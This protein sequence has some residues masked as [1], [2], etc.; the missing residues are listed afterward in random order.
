M[1]LVLGALAPALTPLPRR[2][3]MTATVG[4]VRPAGRGF[5]LMELLV[6]AAV[7]GVVLAAAFG[8]LWSLAAV[9][10]RTDDRAQAATIAAACVRG[11]A[12]KVRQAVGV[13]PP[14]SGRHPARALA[15][16][17]HHP[18]SAAEDVLV[19]WDPSRRVVW[20]NASGTYLADHVAALRV[21]YLLADGRTVPGELM[22]PCGWTVV[23]GVHV[24]LAVVVGAAA[25]E[26]SA[27]ISLGPA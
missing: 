25:A 7:A 16:L 18:G 26:R 21:A 23:R 19:V 27:L 22:G 6:A 15:L 9:A 17:H 2:C 14:P 12:W 24:D 10:A 11:I 8:W 20:R 13:A 3:G 4:H 1:R 5:S